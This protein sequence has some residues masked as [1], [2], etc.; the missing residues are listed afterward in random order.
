MFPHLLWESRRLSS[1]LLNIPGKT[2]N[3]ISKSTRQTSWAPY[4][5][6]CPSKTVLLSHCFSTHKSRLKVSHSILQL[7]SCVIAVLLHPN[8]AGGIL[9]GLRLT[10]SL[11]RPSPF[12]PNQVINLKV[13]FWLIR[14]VYVSL[15]MSTEWIW[16]ICSTAAGCC[17]L[18]LQCP[19]EGISLSILELVGLYSSF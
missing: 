9:C 11:H 10:C 8:A 13:F 1:L 4:T 12:N 14:I 16:G 3:S 15:K 19:Q 2:P 5:L 6:T 17:P 18:C 7:V